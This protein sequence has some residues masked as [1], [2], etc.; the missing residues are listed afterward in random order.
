MHKHRFAQIHLW[1][2]LLNNIAHRSFPSCASWI[3]TENLLWPSGLLYEPQTGCCCLSHG[4]SP[5]LLLPGEALKSQLGP[6]RHF[7]GVYSLLV[8]LEKPVLILLVEATDAFVHTVQ[9]ISGRVTNA[10]S[11]KFG[12]RVWLRG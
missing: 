12:M 2:P 3:L 5:Y 8:V 4:H 1:L 9:L 6:I 10:G 11:L 7:T